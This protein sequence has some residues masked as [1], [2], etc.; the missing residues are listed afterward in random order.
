MQ[1][2]VVIEIITQADGRIAAPVNAY[3]NE[4]DARSKFH[5]VMKQAY[6]SNY[7]V[8]SCM[9]MT[10]EAFK[11]EDECVKHEVQPEPEPTPEPEG[12]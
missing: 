12:E 6:R 8:H 11:L 7:P 1:K 3:E 4:A 5:D 10:S 2:F 9:L